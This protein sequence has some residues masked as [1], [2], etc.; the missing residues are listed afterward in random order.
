MALDELMHTEYFASL[1][2]DRFGAA[3]VDR[4]SRA[5]SEQAQALPLILTAISTVEA[6]MI[7]FTLIEKQVAAHL[8]PSLWDDKESE[9]RVARILAIAMGSAHPR[10]LPPHK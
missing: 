4:I 6:R 8:R 10:Q 3:L 9:E 5:S 1:D 7:A 2:R